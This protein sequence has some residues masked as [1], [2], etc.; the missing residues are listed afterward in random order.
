[1][2]R[3]TFFAALCLVGVAGARAQEPAPLVDAHGD[4]LPKHAV[5]RLGTIRFRHSAYI[6][7]IAYLPDGKRIMSL[8]KAKS[9]RLWD[10]NG[11]PLPIPKAIL[12]A[13]TSW[14]GLSGDGA[15][16]AC[17]QPE[18]KDLSSLEQARWGVRGKVRIFELATGR[19]CWEVPTKLDREGTAA[20]SPDGKTVVVPTPRGNGATGLQVWD[21]QT[22]SRVRSLE[23]PDSSVTVLAISPD[24]KLLASGGDDT[25]VRL[26]DLPNGKLLHKL[27]GHENTLSVLSFARD[28]KFLASGADDDTVRLW[29][30]ATG[31]MERSISRPGN[32]FD[33]AFS[34]NGE[35]LASSPGKVDGVDI[36]ETKTGKARPLRVNDFGVSALVFSPDGRSLACGLT[37]ISIWNVASGKRSSVLS[38]HE[39]PVWSLSFPGDE[40]TLCSV[41]RDGTVSLWDT[42]AR[43][44][45]RQTQAD[46]GSLRHL[47]VDGANS[48]VFSHNGKVAAAVADRWTIQLCEAASHRKIVDVY[49]EPDSFDEICSLVV[50]TDAR[51][52]ASGSAK[53]RIRLWD[54]LTLEQV[55]ELSGEGGAVRSLIAFPK[56]KHLLAAG[57]ANSTILIW[58]VGSLLRERAKADHKETAAA[59]KLHWGKLGS[60]DDDDARR[61]LWALASVPDLAVPL[62]KDKVRPVSPAD[63]K[64]IDELIADLSSDKFAARDAASKELARIGDPADEALRKKLAEN[65]GLEHR[66][67][68]ETALK[69]SATWQ[70][71]FTRAIELLENIADPAAREVLET[72]ARGAGESRIT[73]QAKAA[74]ERLAQ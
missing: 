29:K 13:P 37:S 49:T 73:R 24:C 26:W 9:L 54:L 58:D 33:L 22:E 1:M 57:Y 71:Q 56:S 74:L 12:A 3:A 72:I 47:F 68:V 59:L 67:R 2:I 39:L 27:T 69:R 55:G 4:P 21:I 66:S 63:G 61:S 34:P 23:V 28:S 52:L 38:A 42:A 11:K 30:L 60:A 65:I 15:R 51:I 70:R 43:R 19:L 17:L 25:I 36:W 6:T 45:L 32:S 48:S 8:D 62:T 14:F 16:V 35:L 31:K 53:G 5:A 44:L 50:L 10:A 64:R 41:S 20:M 7:Q 46:L 18:P 40:K